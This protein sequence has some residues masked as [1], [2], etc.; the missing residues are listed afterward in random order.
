MLTKVPENKI[1]KHI[2][3][4]LLD[5]NKDNKDKENGGRGGEE[6]ERKT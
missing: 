2:A 3:S 6:K 1:Q 4:F 5:H